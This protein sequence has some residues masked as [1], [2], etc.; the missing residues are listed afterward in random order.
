MPQLSGAV[1]GKETV[2]SQLLKLLIAVKSDK[3]GGGVKSWTV[4]LVIQVLIFPF[5]SSTVSVIT[6]GLV[7]MSEQSNVVAGILK[8][9]V[10]QLSE[11]FASNSAA[12]KA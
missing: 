6:C 7:A 8:F 4:T 3:K 5:P 12:V 1:E 2:A 10:P 9:V 11:L